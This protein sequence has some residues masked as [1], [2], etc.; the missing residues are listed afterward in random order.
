MITIAEKFYH[1][2]ITICHALDYKILLYHNGSQD[3]YNL[4]ST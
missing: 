2:V 1:R 4:Q 3:H